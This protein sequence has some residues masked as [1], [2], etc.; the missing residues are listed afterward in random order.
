MVHKVL[1]RPQAEADL[2]HLFDY[3]RDKSG[4]QTALGYI[5]RIR[6]YCEGFSTAAE[7]GRRRDDIRQGLRIV[8]FERSA[9]IIFE[10]TPT[11]VRI[12]R[13]AY[14]GRD[15]DAL[16]AEDDDPPAS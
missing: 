8:G 13:I 9:V 14:R 12:G 1:F 10:A 6:T 16:L 3:I 7:R 4:P 11:T 15:I 2:E 5:R